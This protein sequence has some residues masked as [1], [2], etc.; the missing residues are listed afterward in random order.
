MKPTLKNIIANAG[1]IPESLIKAVIRQSGGLARFVE[2]AP[3]ISNHGISGGFSGWIY[4]NETEP[5]AKRNR[6]AIAEMAKNQAEDFGSTVSEMV[7][8]FGQF[9]NSKDKPSEA[10]IWEALTSG[11]DGSGHNLLNIFAW[12]AAEEVARIVYD[13]LDA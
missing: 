7:Q 3:D 2:M 11:K 9:R 6:K 8:G 5:F 13:M 12:Y 4:Y 1:N 10:E